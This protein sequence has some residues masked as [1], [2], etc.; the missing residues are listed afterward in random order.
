MRPLGSPVFAVNIAGCAL[1]AIAWSMGL[2]HQI[3]HPMAAFLLPAAMVVTDALLRG[4]VVK[5]PLDDTTAVDVLAIYD[6]I[7]LR[8]TVFVTAVHASV[9]A[10]LLG[11]LDGH[12][13]AGRIV[14]LMLGFTMI[15]VGNL[16]PRT[17]PNLAIGIRTRRTLSDPALWMRVHRTAGYLVVACGAVV[18]LSAMLLPGHVGSGM[19]LL[20]GPIAFVATWFLIPSAARHAGA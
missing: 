20:V 5:H 12:A 16:L 4:L 11:M 13:W 1:G 9:L 19:I 15:G 14:P 2:P 8:V 6:A 3:P 10:G 18:V 17:R 7:M